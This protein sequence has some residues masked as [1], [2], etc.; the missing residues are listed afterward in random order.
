MPMVFLLLFLIATMLL[1]E[2]L[3]DFYF[4]KKKQANKAT[5]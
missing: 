2:H 1:N 5:W 4:R 3:F